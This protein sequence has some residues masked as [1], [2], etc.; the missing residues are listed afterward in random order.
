[1]EITYDKEYTEELNRLLIGPDK[2]VVK[3]IG[4]HVT[5]LTGP[6]L[7]QSWGKHHVPQEEWLQ[8]DE[9][10]PM[11]MWEQGLQFERVVGG[12]DKQVPKA[13]CPYCHVVSTVPIP[14]ILSDGSLEEVAKC[15][16]CHTR[17]II[18]TPDFY[19]VVDGKRIIHEAKQTRKSQRQGPEGAPWWIEQLKSYVLF[20]RVAN[21]DA[22][23][24]GRL[25]INW[26][27]GNWGSRKKGKRPRP[28]RSAV[29]G[30]R[31]TFDDTEWPLWKD[32]LL[33]RKAIVEGKEMPPLNGMG[34]GDERSPAYDW[35]CPS[36]PVGKAMGCEMW[37]WD[38]NDN[39]IIVGG[40]QDDLQTDEQGL[41]DR[42]ADGIS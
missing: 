10:G 33:R 12:G 9:D 35:A 18:G 32:E 24:W 5:D 16:I 1:M 13:Y 39:E 20:D 41:T 3:R 29:E 15:T 31:V 30:F 28:P 37:K 27:M 6:C 8:D 4:T 25:P 14:T 34:E 21:P 40:V 36:C 42:E 26:L 7:R 23:N 11:V 19:R 38:D 17:W 22:P 2:P